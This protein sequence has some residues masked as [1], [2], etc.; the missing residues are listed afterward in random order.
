MEMVIQKIFEVLPP[1][2]QTIFLCNQS[3][4]LFIFL[5]VCPLVRTNLCQS[6]SPGDVGE[7]ILPCGYL[8]TLYFVCQNLSRSSSLTA[9]RIR[10][11]Q[12]YFATSPF[13]RSALL[14]FNICSVSGDIQGYLGGITWLSIPGNI[15]TCICFFPGYSGHQSQSTHADISVLQYEAETQPLKKTEVGSQNQ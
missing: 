13:S 9:F 1:P 2:V 15:F 5:S 12:Q 7:I 11:R 3:F 8:Q 10:F 14:S 6:R 4:A